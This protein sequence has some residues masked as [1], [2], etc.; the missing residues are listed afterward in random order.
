MSAFEPRSF[1]SPLAR[2]DAML[3]VGV[4]PARVRVPV[5]R[6]PAPT[7]GD[8]HPQAAVLAEREH[9]RTGRARNLGR[10]IG[11][12]VVDDEHVPFRKLLPKLLE[13]RPQVLLLVPRRD[14]DDGVGHG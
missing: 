8:P 4:H 14:E 11:R 5:L 7:R 2:T 12:A 13:H 3:P 9:L 10:S 1:D 6:R